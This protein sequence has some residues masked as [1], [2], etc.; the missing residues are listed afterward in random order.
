MVRNITS[1]GRN[2]LSDWM[3]QRVS[4]VILGV[5]FVGLLGWMVATPGLDYATWQAL[6][7]AT[8]M[9]IA[10]LAA[11]LSLCAHAWI[12]MWTV[13]TDYLTND[14]MGSKGTA[15]RVLFQ[16]ACLLLIFIYL[17]WGVQILWG[18]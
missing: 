2:G 11:L 4:A 16:V 9:R 5:Y 15:L 7:N 18:L 3:I 6:F 8:W 14:L 10:S 1:F 17:V 12:G 13:S